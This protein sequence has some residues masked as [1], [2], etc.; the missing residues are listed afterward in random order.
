[1]EQKEFQLYKERSFS[2]K[3][4]DTFGFLRDNWR[5][6]GLWNIYL[7]FPVCLLLAVPMNQTFSQLTDLFSNN[8]VGAE[9]LAKVPGGDAAGFINVLLSLFVFALMVTLVQLYMEREQKLENLTFKELQTPLFANL[10]Y[11]VLMSLVFF[12]FFIGFLFGMVMMGV[13]MM[14]LFGPIVLFVVL[15]ATAVVLT[16]IMALI[17][18]V[19]LMERQEG[20]GLFESFR[21]GFRLGWHTWGGLAGLLFVLFIVMMIL[22]LVL[23]GPAIVTWIV[24]LVSAKKAGAAYEAPSALASFGRYL[25]S[26][27]M[28]FGGE[29]VTIPMIMGTI[30]HYGHAREK[31]DGVTVDEEIDSFDT[32]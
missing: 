18:V 17:P 22:S 27:L 8:V 32:L 14:E 28:I 21:K 30:V 20:L 9:A 7:I 19:Y 12:L 26:V 29:L 25:L 16:P 2:E 13:V 6:I 11:S 31:L 1:M 23:Q 15:L 10:G 3:L 5:V 4:N 24:D